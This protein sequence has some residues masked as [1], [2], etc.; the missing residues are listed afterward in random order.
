MSK[1]TCL[2]PSCLAPLGNMEHAWDLKIVF[3]KLIMRL[4]AVVST[5]TEV[6]AAFVFT[7][8]YSIQRVLIPS[9][10]YRRTLYIYNV[11]DV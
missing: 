6:D 4:D 10:L 11:R 2:V 7:F 9:Y 8:P 1:A 3:S 5:C